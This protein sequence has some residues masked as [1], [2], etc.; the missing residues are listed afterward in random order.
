MSKSNLSKSKLSQNNLSKLSIEEYNKFLQESGIKELIELKNN[1][2]DIYYNSGETELSDTRYDMLVETI[3]KRDKKYNITIGAKLREGENRVELPFW[4]GSADKITPDTPKVLDRW[5]KKY[6]NIKYIVTE[7]LDGVSCLY[8]K[9]GD[10]VALYTRGDGK[11]GADISYL[12][13]SFNIPEI[14][15]NI[16]IRGEL[17]MSKSDFK[18]YPNY[19]NARNMVAGLIGSKTAREGLSDIHFV[20]Y[21]IVDDNMY[22]QSKQLEKLKKYGFE[23]PKFTILDSIDI[24]T[25]STLYDSFRKESQYQLDGI[26]VQSDIPYDRN[27]SGN[28][29]YMFAFKMNKEEDIFQTEVIDIEWNISKWGQIKPVVIVK[30]VDISGITI[31]RATAHTAKYIEENKLGPGSIVAITRSKDVI[32]YI[33]DVVRS[34]KAKMP[35]IEYKWDDNHVN[36][37]TK[38]EDKISD[39]K[40]ISDFFAKLGIKYVS[41]ATVK[42]MYDDGLDSLF[43]IIEADKK[44]LMKI[45]TI[46]EL[47]ATK[48]VDN[49][50][51]GLK[52]MN[53]ATVLGASCVLGYGVAEKKVEALLEALPNILTDYKDYS[54]KKNVQRIKNIDGFSDITAE[55]I[56]PHLGGAAEFIQKLSKYGT[57]KIPEKISSTLQDK[58]IVMTGFRDKV[59]EEEIKKRGG[60]CS[61]S[62]SKNTDI[63]IV[64]DINSTSE[65]ANKARELGITLMN[66]NAFENLYL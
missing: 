22:E 42:K 5:L 54:E 30:P 18:K 61:S 40:I 3:K 41:E 28:P 15:D 20:T 50:K 46:K 52:D 6:N 49:I 64:D 66:K 16:S 29:D 60:K 39:I 35:V 43:K 47:T 32:P 23:I 25:L 2:D 55:R 45:P 4:L 9:I 65:K 14:K 57:F 12:R 38:T 48:I 7:K 1:L 17:I 13:K 11:I 37:L 27:I 58:K 19:K 36:I 26:I 33:V 63:V 44:R 31:N 10:K 62:V 51:K 21:E 8:Q 56:V 53:M 34:T 59:L 24:D